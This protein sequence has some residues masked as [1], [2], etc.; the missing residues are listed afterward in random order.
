MLFPLARVERPLGR[1]FSYFWVQLY[2]YRPIVSPMTD[3]CMF[4]RLGDTNNNRLLSNI[5]YAQL[6][7]AFFLHITASYR[8]H[9]CI[10]VRCRSKVVTAESLL[11]LSPKSR[12]ESI[13]YSEIFGL[14]ADATDLLVLCCEQL[15]S[16]PQASITTRMHYNILQVVQRHRLVYINNVFQNLTRLASICKFRLEIASVCTSTI[17]YSKHN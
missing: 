15:S 12:L 2:C 5:V 9:L 10:I 8:W 14:A 17:P 16:K 11:S 1:D 13:Q 3:Y 6:F 4:S 7:P